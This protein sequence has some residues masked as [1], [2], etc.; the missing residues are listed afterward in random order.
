M[1]IDY[2]DIVAGITGMLSPAITAALPIAGTILGVG[3]AWKI[4][5]RFTK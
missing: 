4:F 1:T 2:T 5:K 3:I